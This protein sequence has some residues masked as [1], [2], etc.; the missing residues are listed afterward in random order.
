MP[1][2]RICLVPADKSYDKTWNITIDLFL[3]KDGVPTDKMTAFGARGGIAQSSDEIEPFLLYTK[4]ILDFGTDFE[5]RDQ[6][7]KLNIRG[8]KRVV[9]VGELFTYEGPLNDNAEGE[10]TYRVSQ[11]VELQ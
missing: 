1:M 6:N 3:D 7:C 8:S 4:G 5:D 11:V 9:D 2:K 10:L